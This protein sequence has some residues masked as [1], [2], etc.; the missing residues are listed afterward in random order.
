MA[1][2]LTSAKRKLFLKAYV[3]SGTIV[4]AARAVSV[5][6]TLHYDWMKDPEYA[7]AFVEAEKQAIAYLEA[8]LFRRVYEGTEE[9]VV[10]QGELSYRKDKN[11]KLTNKPLT[12]RRKNDTLLIFALKGKK[13]DVYRDN[14]RGEIN[15]TGDM[16]VNHQLTLRTLS[17][18]QLEQL[19]GMFSL[20][21]E[22]P[23]ES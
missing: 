6:D 3:A 12:I 8:E 21:S 17:D 15:V 16:R 9:P 7:A 22:D 19:E 11:G 4:G 20:P 14:F 23:I 1:S 10:Y 5:S 13:P 18:E 2:R